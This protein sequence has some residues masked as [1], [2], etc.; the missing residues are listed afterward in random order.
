M[1]KKLMRHGGATKTTYKM[2]LKRVP[3][4]LMTALL[5]Q[6]KDNMLGNNKMWAVRQRQQ[7]VILQGEKKKDGVEGDMNSWY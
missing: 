1:W 2:K 7:G 6:Q 4:R 3:M 5:H